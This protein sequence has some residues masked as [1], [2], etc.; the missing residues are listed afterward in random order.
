MTWISCPLWMVVA[1]TSEEKPL[2]CD[3]VS[4]NGKAAEEPAQGGDMVF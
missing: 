2:G 3:L 4:D 1:V